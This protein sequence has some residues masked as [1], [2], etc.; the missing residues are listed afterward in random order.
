MSNKDALGNALM[1][2]YAYTFLHER[3]QK[4]GKTKDL[5][6]L[7]LFVPV[8]VNCAFSCE[9]FMKAMLP[10]E[11]RGHELKKLFSLLNSTIAS[12]IKDGVIKMMQETEPNY[13]ESDFENDLAANDEA[14]DHWRY[15]HE[16]KRSPSFNMK[17]MFYF[18]KCLKAF[19][20]IHGQLAK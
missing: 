3:M 4:G 10:A 20:S 2:D 11:T 9:L 6:E 15:F 18:Q 8:A 19:A 12:R 16:G 7:G 1:F 14:F 17:F 13:S 5:K